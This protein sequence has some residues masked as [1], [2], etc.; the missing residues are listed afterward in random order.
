MGL[1]DDLGY[2][3]ENIVF[4]GARLGM[5]REVLKGLVLESIMA[6][7]GVPW[8]PILWRFLPILFLFLDKD[9]VLFYFLFEVLGNIT[10][11]IIF[12]GVGFYQRGR[13]SYLFLFSM[14]A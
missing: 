11:F 2:F 8:L 1:D 4:L 9:Q 14:I 10:L 13:R 6:R 12:L 5:R 7:D 3:G